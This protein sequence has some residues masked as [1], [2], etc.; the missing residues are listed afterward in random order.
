MRVHI[1]SPANDPQFRFTRNQWDDALARASDISEP[2]VLTIGDTQAELSD[3]MRE[4]E[5]LITDA[6]TIGRYFPGPA[7]QL[8]LLFATAAGLDGLAPFDW[9]PAGTALLN[10]RG[11][12][13]DKAGEYA[14]M[15][16]LM[17]AGRAVEFATD[18]REQR[19][20]KR[21]GS[22][23]RNRRVTIIGLGGLGGA[24]AMQCR[25]FG[26]HVTGVRTR[27][28]A[29]EHCD[30]VITPAGL[31]RLL[32][33]T[34]FL[35]LA[36]PLTPATRG[37]IDRRRI[38]LLPAGAGLVNIGRGALID[39]DA[40]CNALDAGRLRG[41]VLDVFEPEPVP[42]GHR[43]WTTRNLVMT[44][45]VSADDPVTYNADSLDLFF[46]NLRAYR[47]GLPLPNRFDISRGY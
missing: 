46:D 43:L 41:A 27:S 11:A 25:R 8:K 5:A 29:H 4:A 36:C 30:E 10:N 3:A 39:Q 37:M 16:V 20:V 31:D 7:P 6:R 13:A 35:I 23:L 9:L 33:D 34:E 38:G 1:Q 12:H 47:A 19:W 17:L 32:P 22:V 44:P 42:P 28:G 2:H 40:L 15:A 21:Y 45:H 26:M 14:I 18:Q 24:A